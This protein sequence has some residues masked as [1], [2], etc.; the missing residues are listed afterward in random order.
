MLFGLP[1]YSSSI[2]SKPLRYVLLPG[3]CLTFCRVTSD[4]ALS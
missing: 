1:M 3:P 2:R 4:A